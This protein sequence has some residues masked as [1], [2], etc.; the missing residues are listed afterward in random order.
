MGGC[1]EGVD[2]K[3]EGLGERV[4]GGLGYNEWDGWR[5]WDKGCGG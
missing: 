2:C 1:G 3:W 4:C 5:V